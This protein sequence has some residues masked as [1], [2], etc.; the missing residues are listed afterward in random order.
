MRKK[1]GIIT[2]VTA[3]A[4]LLTAGIAGA[5]VKYLPMTEFG[6]RVPVKNLY[7]Q[8]GKSAAGT[9]INATKARLGAGLEG[10]KNGQSVRVTYVGSGMVRI[11]N[12]ATGRI[13]SVEVTESVP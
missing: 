7:S 4:L 6:I 9:V 10:A 2:I 12:Q 8:E 11:E 1:L 13:V 5:V 3:V